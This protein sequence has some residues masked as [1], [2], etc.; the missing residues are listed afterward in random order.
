MLAST[1]TSS[2]SAL[3]SRA[4][5]KLAMLEEAASSAR[6]V[7]LGYGEEAHEAQRRLSELQNERDR[8]TNWKRPGYVAKDHPLVVEIE[9][10]IAIA[11]DIRDRKQD[12]ATSAWEEARLTRACVSAIAKWMESVRTHVVTDARLGDPKLL[13]DETPAIA[14]GK[15]R[16]RIAELKANLDQIKSTPIHSSE[17]KAFCV[18]YVAEL[19]EA[20]R[21]DLHWLLDG[22]VRRI[23]WHDPA[24]RGS[25]DRQYG[26][27]AAPAAI[28]H[29]AWMD[30]KGFLTALH[31]QVDEEA[32]DSIALKADDRTRK[33]ASIQ[34]ELLSLERSEEHWVATLE[35]DGAKM[36]RRSD[37]DPRAVLGL[38]GDL[39][40]PNNN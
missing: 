40:P 28:A 33:S 35:K 37:A 32:D 12:R 8:L 3:T 31:R 21:A 14:I 29:I 15:L 1:Q 18:S 34:T 10:Q 6:Y 17:A 23:D 39:P 4:A 16:G 38:S 13:R 5:A 20:G 25:A 2:N 11:Q 27:E 22:G 36:A 26:T 24:H 7:A 19:V 9:K 30:P